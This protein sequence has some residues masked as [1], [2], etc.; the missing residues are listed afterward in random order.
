MIQIRLRRFRRHWYEHAV[1]HL[2]V[3]AVIR[4]PAS[5]VDAVVYDAACR[6]T[7]TAEASIGAVR[8]L[9]ERASRR[10]SLR[11]FRFA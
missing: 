5:E 11:H 1:I 2:F 8:G 6:A 7:L 4:L 9:G 10:G 3:H